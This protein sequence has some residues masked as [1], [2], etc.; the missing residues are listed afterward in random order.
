MF[1]TRINFANFLLDMDRSSS[2][3]A[4][5]PAGVGLAY[6]MHTDFFT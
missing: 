5:Q 1:V 3:S 2:R 6:D 4:C